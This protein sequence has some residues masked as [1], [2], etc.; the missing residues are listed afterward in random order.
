MSKKWVAGA[1]KH[2]GALHEELHVPEGEKIPAKKLEKAE[3][4]GGKL[5]QRA[6]LAETLKDMPHGYGPGD[7]HESAGSHGMQMGE[8]G[9]GMLHGEE[10][11]TRERHPTHGHDHSSHGMGKSFGTLYE[12]QDRANK[13]AVSGTPTSVIASKHSGQFVVAKKPGLSSGTRGG[14]FHVSRNGKKVYDE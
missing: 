7:V 9:F 3:H 13:L 6:R 4:S 11:G 14:K 10:G 12:A 1:I 2:P 8:D 5:G